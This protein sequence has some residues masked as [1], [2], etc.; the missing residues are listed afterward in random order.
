MKLMK[1]DTGRQCGPHGEGY[2]VDLSAS[3]GCTA[4]MAGAG[5]VHRLAG[6]VAAMTDIDW[7]TCFRRP[8]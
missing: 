4:Q 3:N 5:S 2:T 8:M 7:L 6:A 1:T